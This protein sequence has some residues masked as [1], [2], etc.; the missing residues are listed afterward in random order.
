MAL[1]GPLTYTHI[2]YSDTE[3]QDLVITQPDGSSETIQVPKETYRIENYD[4]VYVYVKSI[5]MHTLTMDGEKKEHVYFHLAGYE[6][7]EARDADNENFLFFQG[8]E[9][10]GYDHNVNLWSQVYAA[11]K[12]NEI[13]A[14]LTD[15]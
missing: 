11:I 13:F 5:Q 3:T 4:N 6:S 7:K 14:D 10:Y 8:H 12:A 1:Q 9:L 15:V 2:D